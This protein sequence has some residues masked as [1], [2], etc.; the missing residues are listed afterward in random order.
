MSGISLSFV[1]TLAQELGKMRDRLEFQEPILIVQDSIVRMVYLMKKL[2]VTNR[3]NYFVDGKGFLYI[4]N[5]RMVKLQEFLDSKTV[6]RDTLFLRFSD[7]DYKSFYQI[8]HFLKRNS[9][10]GVSFEPTLDAF[11]FHFKSFDEEQYKDLRYIILPEKK[12]ETLDRI[13]FRSYKILE[14]R[15]SLILIAPDR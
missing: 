12:Q 1:P 3:V 8:I 2:P 10:D 5:T 6:R 11:A 4:N 14:Q 9:I 13:K 15:S 7:S